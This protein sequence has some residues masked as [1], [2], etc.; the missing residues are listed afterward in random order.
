MLG[1]GSGLVMVRLSVIRVRSRDRCPRRW[2]P[3]GGGCPEGGMSY[4]RLAPA[5]RRHTARRLVTAKSSAFVRRHFIRLHADWYIATAPI[6]RR[7]SMPTFLRPE[8]REAEARPAFLQ[9]LLRLRLI[10]S[11]ARRCII[12]TAENGSTQKHSSESIITNKA[13]TAKTATKSTTVVDTCN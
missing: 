13:E 12:F 5:L 3:E 10:I 4:N 2:L 9:P 7:V 6:L 11:S 1:Y 8:T